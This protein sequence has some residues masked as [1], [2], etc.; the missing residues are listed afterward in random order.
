MIRPATAADADAVMAVA[1]AAFEHYPRHGYVETGR[2]TVR[3]RH[4]VFFEK[5]L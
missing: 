4:R 3:D 2:E 1:E 5:V